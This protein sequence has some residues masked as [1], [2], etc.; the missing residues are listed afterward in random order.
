[1]Y[2]INVDIGKGIPGL[3]EI[4]QSHCNSNHRVNIS[5]NGGVLKGG[6]NFKNM[7]VGTEDLTGRSND[8]V[9]ITIVEQF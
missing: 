1:M 4:P 3:M 8:D 2:A 6:H 9:M 7:P 5:V